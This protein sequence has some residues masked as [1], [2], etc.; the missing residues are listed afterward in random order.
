MITRTLTDAQ[1][2]VVE[3]YQGY[4]VPVQWFIGHTYDDGRTE[5]IALGQFAP[6]DEDPRQFVWSL[7]IS[8]DGTDVSTSEAVIPDGFSTGITV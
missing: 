2:K 3:H 6:H 5:V 8:A 7:L 1:T 4:N